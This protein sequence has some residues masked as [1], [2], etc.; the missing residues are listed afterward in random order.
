MHIREQILLAT[1]SSF[2]IGGAARYVIEPHN[3]HELLEA[4]R[5]A[6]RE[7]LEVLLVGGGTNL[8]MPDEGFEGVVIRPR[9]Q[10]LETTAPYIRVGAGVAMEALLTFAI[11]NGLGGLE[12]AGGLPGTVGG[13]IRGNAG[14]FGGE[15][16]DFVHLVE[17]LDTSSGEVR[18]LHNSECRFAYRASIFK[19]Q[20]Q[21][22]II[23][24]ATL[25][26]TPADQVKSAAMI[27][28]KIAYRK[29]RHPMEYPNI[30]SIFKN[31]AVSFLP[32]RMRGQF[33]GVVKADPFPVVP[34]AHLIAEA[35]LKG[36]SCGGAMVSPK[37]PNFIV[38][39]L[40][41]RADEVRALISLV[42]ERVQ[43]KFHIDLEEEVI[44]V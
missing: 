9:F 36:V 41:A 11:H 27:A 30:G 29:A 39:V 2:S 15:M 12:W 35:G 42:K 18:E 24:G 40:T 33:Q 16:K 13:A 17:Y 10:M 44:V 3:I 26:L 22:L 31:V 8:L 37:H 32:E 7:R 1:L 25:A 20:G 6:R 43:E 23:L 4:L 34:A 38:N 28:E 21:R 5:F 14:A 19:E